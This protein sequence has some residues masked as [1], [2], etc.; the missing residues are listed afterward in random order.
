MTEK[1]VF[2]RKDKSGGDSESD[3]ADINALVR[4]WGHH[5]YFYK[6]NH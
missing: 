4:F 1:E 5:V 2:K 3:N 6:F